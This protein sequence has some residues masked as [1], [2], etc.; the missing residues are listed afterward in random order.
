VKIL[1]VYV[2]GYY[3]NY[4]SYNIYA[5]F[6]SREKANKFI[7]DSKKPF[8]KDD[9]IILYDNREIDFHCDEWDLDDFEN[10]EPK[11]K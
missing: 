1:K 9:S 8:Y 10:I 7:K 3:D 2:V 6:S 5:L 4:D 11:T